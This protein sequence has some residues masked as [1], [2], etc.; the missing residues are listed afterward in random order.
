MT[1]KERAM[2]KTLL[3]VAKSTT[4]AGIGL[5]LAM[6]SPARA[7]VITDWNQTAIAAM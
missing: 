2:K 1:F 7:D 4:V 3:A 6:S 5:V